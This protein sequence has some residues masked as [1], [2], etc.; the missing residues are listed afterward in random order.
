VDARNALVSLNISRLK[1]I[2]VQGVHLANTSIS[3]EKV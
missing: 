1:K 3:V 2:P